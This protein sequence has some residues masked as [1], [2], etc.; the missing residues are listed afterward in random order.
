MFDIPRGKGG[1]RKNSRRKDK[2]ES[3]PAKTVVDGGNRSRPKKAKSSFDTGKI[4]DEVLDQAYIYLGLSELDI[5]EKIAK[6]VAREVVEAVV[7]GYSSRPSPD[8]VLKRI[9]RN[10]ELVNEYIA[11]KILESIEKPGPLTLEFLIANGGRAVIKDVSRLYKLAVEYNKPE[12]IITLQSLWNKYGPKEMLK[13]PRCGF[14]GISPEYSCVV[15]GA[16]VSEKYIRDSIGFSDKFNTYL[17]TASVAELREVL[18]LGFI[19]VDSLRVYTP[20][21]PEARGRVLYPIRLTRAEIN[22][23]IEEINSRDVRI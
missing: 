11:G 20:K 10:R 9:Q 4:V 16:T 22:S 6:S 2:G 1:Q 23:I 21:S 8:S 14:N 19:L 18:Q 7:S 13:C 3:T 12:L 15:C 5:D 17:K